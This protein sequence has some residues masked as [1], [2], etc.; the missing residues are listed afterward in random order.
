[1]SSERTVL[2]RFQL[3]AERIVE[4]AS[5]SFSVCWLSHVAT[6][7][8]YMISL[9]NLRWSLYTYKSNYRFPFIERSRKQQTLNMCNIEVNIHLLI[10]CETDTSRAGHFAYAHQ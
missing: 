8:T 9:L 1:M 4:A 2:K 5:A 3:E 7:V 10:A 6:G